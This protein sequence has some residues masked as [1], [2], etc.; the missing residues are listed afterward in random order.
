M[1]PFGASLSQLLEAK[2][3]AMGVVVVVTALSRALLGVAGG[4][5]GDMGSRGVYSRSL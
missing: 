3:L 5:L 1:K 2:F 4:E